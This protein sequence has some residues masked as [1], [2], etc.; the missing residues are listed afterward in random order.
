VLEDGAA[1]RAVFVAPGS[2]KTPL[3]VTDSVRQTGSPKFLVQAFASPAV[4]PGPERASR[5]GGTLVIDA[6]FMGAGGR[7]SR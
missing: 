3:T 2:P 5:T 1:P 4:P 7:G 6:F